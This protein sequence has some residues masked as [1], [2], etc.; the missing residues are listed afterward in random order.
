MLLSELVSLLKDIAGKENVSAEKE[1]LLC[2]S[3]DATQIESLPDI[4]VKPT[5]PSQ[6]SEMI[7][8]SNKEDM[9]VIPRG[10]GTGFS[11]GSIPVKGGILLSFEKMN[12]II[13]I[14]E[15]NLFAIV[16][17]GVINGDLQRLAESK[18]LFYPPDPSSMEFCTLGGNVAENAGG[19]K[20][21]K[22]GVT[23]DYVMGLE[24]VLP[25]GK[26]INTGVK[27]RK[28]VVGYDFTRLMTGSEG[29]LGVITKIILKLLPMPEKVSTLS[30]FFTDIADAAR[31]VVDITKKRIVPRAIEFMDKN[32]LEV[33]K[34][35][36]PEGLQEKAEAL[37]LIEV[38]GTEIEAPRILE[39]VKDA[40]KANNAARIDIA[41]KESDAKRLW[42]ARRS[43][44]QNMFKL[45]PDKINED[46]V[47]PRTRIPDI[48]SA[49]DG[50]S[51]KYNLKIVNF[52][53]AGDGNI[54]VNIMYDKKDA[55]ETNRAN[56]AVK[57]I[58]SATLSL[59]GTIS[60]EHGIGI[61]KAPYL[62]MELGELGVD[63]MKRIKK[64]F[65]PNNILNP[66]KIFPDETTSKS[67]D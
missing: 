2:Y 6:I 7:K 60:G 43:L 56:D 36:L 53:H 30:A 21:V 41:E 33:V 11:G 61:T 63:V 46:I 3:Y 67:R 17:P 28:G 9:P 39:K 51:K 29:T 40:C 59:N 49:V 31:T 45:K 15:D 14:D 22:Y 35:H 47:V 50:I 37:L 48:I 54:H 66:G 27:T 1:E 16:E 25:T 32:S 38:D 44:S 62:K 58:F 12:R 19:P 26:I 55:D 52:G 10:A 8:L 42:L 57:D 18:G 24:V 65:D 5:L 4:I 13:E 34:E 64:S 20:A 23:R